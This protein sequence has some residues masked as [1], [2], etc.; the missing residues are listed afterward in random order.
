MPSLCGISSLD[1]FKQY[2]FKIYSTTSQVNFA[3]G[4][5]PRSNYESGIDAAVNAAFKSSDIAIVTVSSALWQ[6]C[7]SRK[8]PTHCLFT[9]M[10]RSVPG[11]SNKH[12]CRQRTRFGHEFHCRRVRWLVKSCAT[13]PAETGTGR[14]ARWRQSV[15]L[16]LLVFTNGKPIAEPWIQAN[17]MSS[18][19]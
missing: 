18:F 7:S 16:L 6:W 19:I 8:S 13:G 3:G 10:L 4:C 15:S 12:Y 1:G 14:E 17:I 11:H 5:K 9:G 2:L